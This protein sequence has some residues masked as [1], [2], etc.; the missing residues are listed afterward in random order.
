[1]A[2][3]EPGLLGL[4]QVAALKA[5]IDASLARSGVTGNADLMAIVS[6][7]EGR[8]DAWLVSRIDPV[9]RHAGLPPQVRDQIAA[10]EWVSLTADVHQA[11]SG[12]L[13][14][15][16]RDV[17]GADQLRALVSSTVN[18]AKV[19]LSR[20]ARLGGLLNSVTTGG[21][22]TRVELSFEVPAELLDMFG[23]GIVPGPIGELAH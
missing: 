12:R 2:F 4:G 18:A 9:A 16:T 8:G 14:L 10:V 6:S 11:V 1:V 5:A 20:D 3:L 23:T 22:G 21:T 17:Q 19:V 13:T 15:E 7:V